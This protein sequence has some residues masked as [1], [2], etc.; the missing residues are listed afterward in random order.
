MLHSKE[1]VQPLLKNIAMLKKKYYF[2]P[3]I[4]MLSQVLHLSGLKSNI[5][6]EALHFKD[7][8]SLISK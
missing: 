7:Y 1:K 6:I 8:Y 5:N 3:F 2:I 4:R